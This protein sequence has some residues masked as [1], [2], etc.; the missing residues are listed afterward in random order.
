MATKPTA[1][2]QLLGLDQAALVEMLRWMILGRRYEEKAAEMYQIGEI[3]GFCHLYIGQEAVAVGALAPLRPDDYVITA[4]RDHVHALLCGMDPGAIMAELFGRV[5]G[6]SK[7]KGGSMHLFDA[8][9][10]FMGG[11]A[12]VG[13]HLPVAVG[14]GYAI[15]YRETD[16][17]CVCFL[18]DSV[19][20]IGAFNEA[21]NMA[22]LFELPVVFIIENNQY[23]MG[24]A[25]HRAAAIENLA[26]RAC[27]YTGMQGWTIDGMDVLEVR[28]TVESA[29]DRARTHKLPSLIEA[30]TY[31]FVGHSMS[32]PNYG[33]YRT[34]EEVSSFKSNDDPI[35]QYIEI[36]KQHQVIKDAD[37]ENIEKDVRKIVDDAVAFAESSP[38]PQP[39][40]L[41]TDIYAGEFPDPKRRDPW[42]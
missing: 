27:A 25:V 17:V 18:G 10:N 35:K 4:Y 21:L 38:H 1:T 28:R 3:G 26:D 16:Q 12:I 2:D 39:E 23:G 15:R 32:D 41:Y 33:H 20:N 9:V 14:I 11:H 22:A 36:L 19:A 42:R 6:C 37:I 30:K 8:S 40:E 24:T 29:I 5:D 13:G 34:K 31:R 7:G